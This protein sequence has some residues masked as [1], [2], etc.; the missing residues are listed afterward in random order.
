MGGWFKAS[1]K[2]QISNVLFYCDLSVFSAG[3]LYL[4]GGIGEFGG[5]ANSMAGGSQ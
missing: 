3:E 4:F 1:A 5:W 2:A